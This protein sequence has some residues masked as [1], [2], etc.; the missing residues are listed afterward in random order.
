MHSTEPIPA[1]L[2]RTA[3]I[4]KTYTVTIGMPTCEHPW[5]V[6]KLVTNGTS[7]QRFYIFE[8]G[9]EDIRKLS[10]IRQ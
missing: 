4:A 8:V 7:D 9:L 6:E 2:I 3:G 10:G 5:F 1:I